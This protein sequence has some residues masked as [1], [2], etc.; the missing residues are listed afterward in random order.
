MPPRCAVCGA[1]CEPAETVCGHCRGALSPRRSGRSHAGG[2]PVVWAA[3]YEGAARELVASLKFRGRLDLARL[4]GACVA[5]A[6]ER[7][8]TDPGGRAV[9]PVP[10]A[11]LRRRRRGFDPGELIAAAAADALAL[12]LVPCLTRRSGRRQVGRRRKV[13]L[14][15]PPRVRVATEPPRAAL[16]IDDVLTTGATIGACATALRGA[17]CLD[18]AAAVFA[19]AL[20]PAAREA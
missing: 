18:I 8:G 17:G 4:A 9:V 3:P 12:P 2:V 15:E 20:G 5:E 16:V 13:R 11:P 14:T 1:A 19:H 7:A 10:A 6:V